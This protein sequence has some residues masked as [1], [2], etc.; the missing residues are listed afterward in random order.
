MKPNES[1]SFTTSLVGVF[2]DGTWQ[3]LYTFRWKSNYKGEPE[4]GGISILGNPSPVE[5]DGSNGR[6]SDLRLNV[7]PA[8]IPAAVR[9]KMTA[10]GAVNASG[11]ATTPLAP[12]DF[13]KR[14]LGR[15]LDGTNRADRLVGTKKNDIINCRNSKDLAFG[16]SGNDQLQG[17]KGKD[18]LNGG[19]GN[20]V[21]IGDLGNDTLIGGKVESSPA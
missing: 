8:N 7:N 10:D 21:L 1:V 18:Q 12:I 20:D 11:I 9:R 14:K 19:T 3:A 16:S 4:S 13:S 5:S 6:V 15:K 17:G 2:P